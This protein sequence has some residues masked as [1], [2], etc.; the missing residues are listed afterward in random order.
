MGEHY[1]DDFISKVAPLIQL[2][3]IKNPAKGTSP[4]EIDLFDRTNN[5]YADLKTQNTPFFSQV[6][7]TSMMVFLMI[8]A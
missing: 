8:R 7:N 6:L 1:E 4:W 5:K 3:I 2:D